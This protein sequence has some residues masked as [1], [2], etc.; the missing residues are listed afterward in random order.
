[1]RHGR[2]VC[3]SALLACLLVP[4]LAAAEPPAIEP[5]ADHAIDTFST[6]P[7]WETTATG[8]VILDRDTGETIWEKGADTRIQPASTTKMMTAICALEELGDGRLDETVTIREEVLATLPEGDLSLAD[9]KAGQQLTVRDLLHCLLLPSGND[10]AVVLADYVSGSIDAFVARMNWW[11][12]TM[13]CTDTHFANPHGLVDEQHW[14]TARDLARI[15]T[16][17]LS[18]PDLAQIAATVTYDL[19]NGADGGTTTLQNTNLLLH[20]ESELYD[21]YAVGVKTGLTPAGGCFVSA[22][23]RPED[24]LRFLCVVAGVPALDAQGQFIEPNPAVTEG[25]RFHQWVYDTFRR[26]TLCQ[27]DSPFAVEVDG[28][29]EPVSALPDRTRTVL[30]PAAQAERLTA[31]FTPA[32]GLQT[33]LK[34]GDWLGSMTWTVD[35]QAVGQTA[36]L[37]AAEDGKQTSVWL[38]PVVGAAVFFGAAAAGL[39]A[40]RVRRR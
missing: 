32:E 28:V 26:V 30:L 29:R 34:A 25:R 18:R 23:E 36:G 16:S 12:E 24:G 33:P 7:D 27:A 39:H 40:L 38:W 9:L 20:P 5:A 17:F 35:G 13:G 6:A 21:P 22:G 1:M 2:R 11:A 31:G 3:L 19:P 10:A 14:S 8:V 37:Y 4:Q 15:A